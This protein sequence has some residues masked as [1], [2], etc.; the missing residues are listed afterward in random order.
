MITCYKANYSSCMK[1]LKP[2]VSSLRFLRIFPYRHVVFKALS[3]WE[4]DLQVAI[5]HSDSYLQPWVRL[6]HCLGN[7]S[8]MV[9]TASRDCPSWERTGSQVQG[10][11]WRAL[12][13]PVPAPILLPKKDSIPAQGVGRGFR[14]G[15]GVSPMCQALPGP[16]L[17]PLNQDPLGEGG[18]GLI[19][20]GHGYTRT[21][22]IFLRALCAQTI[23]GA[24]WLFYFFKWFLK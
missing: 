5:F 4:F 16:Q 3:L 22:G 7:M 18:N 6:G 20:K 11:W 2:K 10:W 24:A 23:W 12:S 13:D 17:T 8:P 15:V 9:G 21:L 19:L 14:D 1:M